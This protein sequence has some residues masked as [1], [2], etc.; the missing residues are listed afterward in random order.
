MKIQYKAALLFFLFSLFFLAAGVIFYDH[1]TDLAIIEKTRISQLSLTNEIALHIESHIEEKS[2]NA[3]ALANT[4]LLRK[5]LRQSNGEY[6]K[7]P[8]RERKNRI[9]LLN[10]RWMETKN[11]NDPFILTYMNNPVAD[12]LKSHQK[13]FPREFGE[14]FLTN[15]YGVIIAT[16]KKLTTLAH[17]HKY[18]WVAGYNEGK[19]RIFLDDRGFDTSVGGYVLGVVIPIA[20]NNEILGILKCNV[21]ILGPLSHMI[22][23]FNKSNRGALKLLRSGGL[24]VI[25]QELEPLSVRVSE[26]VI[27][28]LRKKEKGS[29]MMKLD[30]KM[31][32][33]TYSPVPVTLG[34]E[35]YGFGGKKE[36]IDQIKGNLGEAWHTL[37]IREKSDVLQAT[38][39]AIDF[40]S[41]LGIALSLAMA[42]LALFIGKLISR[43]IVRITGT[44]K[45]IGQGNLDVEITTR[46][47]DELGLLAASVNQM[48]KNL[49]KITASRDDLNREIQERKEAEKALKQSEEKFSKVFENS[50]LMMGIT[51]LEDG[52]I[53]DANNVLLKTFG[54][55]REEMIG[56]TALTLGMYENSAVRESLRMALSDTGH[57][58]ALNIELL[59]KD[60]TKLAI[61]YS[62]EII[63]IGGQQRIFSVFE[64]ITERKRAED[65][66]TLS[67]ANLRRAQQV[68]KM[69]SWSLDL[70]NNNLEW[71]EEVCR[72]FDVPKGTLT[73]EKFLTFVHPGDLE[74]VSEAWE[75]SLSGAPYDIE[76]RIVVNGDEKWVREIAELE[77]EADGK[78]IR[79]IGTVQDISQLKYAEKALLKANK[80][81][82]DMAMQD[83][84]TKIANRRNFDI[85]LKEEWRRMARIKKPLS[86]MIFDV[87]H[88]KLYNDTYGHQAGDNCLQTIARKASRFFKRPGDIIARYGGEEFVVLLPN[89][90]IEGA[91]T[92][93]EK[94]RRKIHETEINHDKSPVGKYVT[95]SSGVSSV[96]PNKSTSHQ[97]LLEVADKNLYEAKKQGRNRVVARNLN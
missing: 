47:K 48:V 80:K 53:I 87:D 77:F 46:S 90:A 93:A 32:L 84:L 52:T 35:K 51:D 42:L 92:L 26:P 63:N 15:R 10:R 14:I 96:I 38:H 7:L 34:S 36:S 61:S 39:D 58:S 16:S 8:E 89:T 82:K 54:F 91:V 88:F 19:G 86:I 64:D 55:S 66:L 81:L 5:A 31:H 70:K 62:G 9:N 2:A 49:K 44:A 67:E 45:K 23:E 79:R 25:A 40:F 65:K 50:P 83:G 68:G 72:I 41:R 17:S 29:K 69:G 24:I 97:I 71:S 1:Y 60:R 13:L 76:H 33:V 4:P 11:I 94:V 37:L 59:K 18:W 22:E 3:L 73:Y 74:I 6:G 43:P 20:L 57:V 85:K 75:A 78:A 27:R 21:N 30:G 56:A 28:E 12:H 95:I